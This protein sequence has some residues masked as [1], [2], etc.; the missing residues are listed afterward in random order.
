[1]KSDQKLLIITT[2]VAMILAVSLYA[3]CTVSVSNTTCVKEGEKTS[4]A[5]GCTYITAI[6]DATGGFDRC[7]S[8]VAVGKTK[9]GDEAGKTPHKC[10]YHTWYSEDCPGH[11]GHADWE[12]CNGNKADQIAVGNPCPAEKPH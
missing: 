10:C 3:Q 4:V 11:F 1:M 12:S 5:N 7:D 9:C 2:G 6:T 8:D